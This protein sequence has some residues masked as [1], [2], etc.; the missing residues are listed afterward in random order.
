MHQVIEAM[1]VPGMP[2]VF[3]L[4]SFERRV[5]IYSQ[6]VRALNLAEA[7]F[8]A[9]EIEPGA[10]VAVVG[11]GAAGLTFAAGAAHHGARVTVLEKEAA[12]LPLFRYAPNRWLHP[13][14]YDWPLPG[15]E[16]ARAGLPV[17]DWN[18]GTVEEVRRQLE[19]GWNEQLAKEGDRLRVL[20]GVT[21]VQITS[22]GERDAWLSWNGPKPGPDQFTAIILAVGFGLEK[23]EV[24]GYRGYWE[25]DDL[26]E[27]SGFRAD[28]DAPRTFLVSGCGDGALTDLLRLCIRDF[29]HDE[30]VEHF[31]NVPGID[32]VAR[33]V[34]AVEEDLRAGS[35]RTPD[36]LF[37]Q[38]QQIKVQAITDR[39]LAR[40]R[41]DV[42]VTLN[43]VEPYFLQAN[44]SALNR[45]LVAQLWHACRF[46]F[47]AGKLR[48][49][50]KDGDRLR[51]TLENGKVRH[52]NRVVLR[53][54]PKPALAQDFEEVWTACGSW[55]ETWK[56]APHL[57]DQTRERY[58]QKGAFGREERFEEAFE[59][60]F[61]HELDAAR[62]FQGR[63]EHLAYLASWLDDAAPPHRVLAFR[64][65]GGTGK[66]TLVQ[67]ALDDYLKRQIGTGAGLPAGV[68]VW[69]FYENGRI[70][71]FLGEACAY[72][73]GEPGEV[74]GR[75]VRLKNEL[76]E[77]APHLFVLD[78]LERVQAEGGAGR[79]RGEIEDPR[80]RSLLSLIAA[81]HLGKARVLVTSRYPLCDLEERPGY[82]ELALED[83]DEATARGVLR[84]WGVVAEDLVLDA[85]AAKVGRH[86]LSVSVLGSFVSRFGMGDPA[87]GLEL[88]LGQVLDAT[89][90][91]DRR[92]R[93]LAALLAHYATR[94]PETEREL[95]VRLAMFPRGVTVE[96]I[97]GLVEAGGNVAGALVGSVPAQLGLQLQKLVTQGLAFGYGAPG[98]RVYTAHPF[99][100]DAF[101][102]L[103]VVPAEEIHEAVRQRLALSLDDRPGGSPS[104]ADSLDQ[105]EA[106]IEHTLLSGKQE[107]AFTL[108]V[109][110]LGGYNNLC[111][112][113]G[114]N[115]R[116]AR[117]LANFSPNGMPKD[118][119]L[120]L[121][122]WQRSM[123]V[124]DW[125]LFAQALGDLHHARRCLAEAE[126]IDRHTS[127]SMD[128]SIGLR[129]TALLEAH[130][131]ELPAAIAHAE[132][133]LF[134]A[135]DTD[136]S[137]EIRRNYATIAFTRALKGEVSKARKYFAQAAGFDGYKLYGSQAFWQ[138]E[139]R[140]RIGARGSARRQ[141]LAEIARGT[142]ARDIPRIHT[143]L[144]HL[145]LRN[146]SS[147]ARHH[148]ALARDWSSRTGDVEVTLRAH[149]LAADIALAANDPRTALHES[150][151]GLDL[152]DTRHFGLYAIDLRLAAARAH[153]ARNSPADALRL[154]TEALTR[155][156]APTC[157]YAW[158]EADAAHLAAIAH[159]ALGDLASAR[160]LF[161]HAADIR[162]RIE[163]PGA[164][165][166]R[167]A[168]DDLAAH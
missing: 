144:G 99:L 32:E 135:M 29:R 129:N 25:P 130:L 148:L 117:I 35:E 165:E 152:A 56:R 96:T 167:A 138:A 114:D 121:S 119:A 168:A 65:I 153:L 15:W 47:L 146:N 61:I 84:S 60:R 156:S 88:D 154:A 49:V 75:E 7:L 158:G 137:E 68:F 57:L 23:E 4:G 97:S 92:A 149:L 79:T 12:P 164:A 27:M 34:R 30:M 74:G 76:R 139:V 110:V 95:M 160:R 2:R 37:K 133:A 151:E 145:V 104:D 55:R 123:L 81:K 102:K 77:G 10:R 22:A 166:S 64:A 14:V 71:D 26:D 103:A 69:S 41:E 122:P 150:T 147:D 131:G 67:R 43:V 142:V 48:S 9:G 52:F 38:Y 155:S 113:L 66:T 63:E 40:K 42:R 94:M 128:L 132:E 87:V 62:H 80:L 1:R 54:G 5:T 45:L 101:R 70:D 108:F 73:T 111:L 93:K 91:A 85:L 127:N 36:F 58:W 116:G 72:F 105:Y 98:K 83:L 106:L 125:G 89:S 143:L 115:A 11:A 157:A 162:A 120:N 107:E 50:E 140:L 3:V 39:I 33:Q 118:C 13:R 51:V 46:D 53:H 59:P 90:D 100:R 6:Q 28:K 31:A 18:A 159:R 124:N 163:H 109:H 17:L 86:A 16:H 44:S 24:P 82:W 21:D 161:E 8:R 126:V 136:D 141:C 134:W 19:A 20:C 78:G 112:R